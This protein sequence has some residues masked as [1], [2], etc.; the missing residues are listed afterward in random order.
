MN[1]EVLTEEHET[2]QLH[3]KLEKQCG[4]TESDEG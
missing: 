1:I 3:G 2:H 4:L